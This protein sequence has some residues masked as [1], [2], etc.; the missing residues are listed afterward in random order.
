[1]SSI[2]TVLNGA[3]ASTGTDD[4]YSLRAAVERALIE[5]EEAIAE[6]IVSEVVRQFGVSEDTVRE[7]LAETGMSVPDR[8]RF[9]FGETEVGITDGGGVEDEEEIEDDDDFFSED[10]VKSAEPKTTAPQGGDD[11]AEAVTA[12]VK[13]ITARL[14]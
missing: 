6:Q 5:R 11:L 7:R 1:M 4:L 10:E 12:L 2:T 13:A 3:I 9:V 14:S 8:V